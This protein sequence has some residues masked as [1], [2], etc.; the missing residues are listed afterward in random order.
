[1]LCVLTA[2]AAVALFGVFPSDRGVPSEARWVGMAFIVVVTV[3]QTAL[4]TAVVVQWRRSHRIEQSL[5]ERRQFE[6]EYQNQRLQLAH[7]TRVAIVGQLSGALAHELTQPLTAILSNAQAAQRVLANDGFDLREVREILQDI[8]D[9]DKRAGEV[10]RRVR[11]LLRR[12]ET[13]VQDIDVPQLIRETL[14]VTRSDLVVRHVE[15]VCRLS[16]HLPG[17][18]ADGVQI[19][20]V[21]LNL[22]L[23]A[24]EAMTE[25]DAQDRR[26]DIIAVHEMGSLRIS[27]A[28]RGPGIAR[29]QLERIFEAFY[30]TKQE[31]LGLGLA[32]CRSI[33]VAHG[34][35]LWATSD[36]RHGST[37]HFTLP[38]VPDARRR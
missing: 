17:V 31:G 24:A 26:I 16:D 33:V 8:V 3:L 36:G 22:I 27:V 11:T 15:V 28:D 34:G 13:Q 23:N 12:G 38:S 1:M 21:L 30:S 4:I 9:D 29:D 6:A 32:I 5:A 2:V 10:I 35:S 14:T 7:L 37:F 19:Q 18:R 20:Q 25:N